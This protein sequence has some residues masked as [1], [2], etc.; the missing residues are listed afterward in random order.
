MI[1]AGTILL[2]VNIMSLLRV[3]DN[4]IVKVNSP[5]VI[6]RQGVESVVNVSVQV[7]PGFHIQAHEVKD[8][9]LIPTTLEITGTTEIIPGKP[10]FPST[11]KFKLEGTDSFLDVFDG[12]FQIQ[13]FLTTQK[14]IQKGNYTLNGKLKYQACDSVRC[15]FPRT[16]EFVVNVD[17][18]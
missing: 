7:K 10:V 4:E 12:T 1:K 3:G 9:Y 15:L 8:E 16:V 14:T 5:K 17:V 18:Q 2:L 13:T 6:T 11:N